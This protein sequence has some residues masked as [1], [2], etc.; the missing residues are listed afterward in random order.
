MKFFGVA[1]SMCFFMRALLMVAL[2]LSLSP[3]VLVLDV[4]APAY[5]VNVLI[6]FMI[7]VGAF[8]FYALVIEKNR[9]KTKSFLSKSSK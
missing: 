9:Q 1:L 2:E 7:R 4:D 3:F 5:A 8:A 6:F